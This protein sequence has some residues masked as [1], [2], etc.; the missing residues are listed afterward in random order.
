MQNEP[1]IKSNILKSTEIKEQRWEG[2]HLYGLRNSLHSEKSF[3]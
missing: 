2:C 3:P 1:N